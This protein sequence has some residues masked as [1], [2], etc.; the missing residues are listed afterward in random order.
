MLSWWRSRCAVCL[1]DWALGLCG[2][3]VGLLSRQCPY[4]CH[5]HR[6]RCCLY[7]G[8]S[9]IVSLSFSLLKIEERLV[10]SFSTS[11]CGPSFVLYWGMFGEQ[12]SH[13]FLVLNTCRWLLYQLHVSQRHS[14]ECMAKSRLADQWAQYLIDCLCYH[15]QPRLPSLW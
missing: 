9:L 12:G 11:S 10:F 13:F 5:F 1:D 7:Q 14:H 3:A 4:P 6:R 15:P 2:C 8:S